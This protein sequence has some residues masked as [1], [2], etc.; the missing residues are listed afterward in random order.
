MCE[1][2]PGKIED[3][4]NNDISSKIISQHQEE[5]SPLN[6]QA[7]CNNESNQG[8]HRQSQ[9]SAARIETDGTANNEFHYRNYLN[10]LEI[11][12]DVAQRCQDQHQL[13]LSPLNSNMSPP[14][15]TLISPALQQANIQN[16][17]SETTLLSHLPHSLPHQ[18]SS[19]IEA[20]RPAKAVAQGLASKVILDRHLSGLK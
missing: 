13:F 11:D 15:S 5:I 14:L 2:V 18:Q 1:S 9:N 20:A 6:Q 12:L 8:S 10:Q 16:G 4:E 17:A 3:T 7:S 19:A